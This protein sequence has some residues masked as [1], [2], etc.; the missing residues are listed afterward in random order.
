MFK[1]SLKFA[2]LVDGPDEKPVV[3]LDGEVTE[4]WGDCETRSAGVGSDV[5]APPCLTR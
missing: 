1:T 4:V 2:G 5:E 3:E